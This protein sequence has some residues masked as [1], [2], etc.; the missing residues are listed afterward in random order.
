MTSCSRNAN[1]YC[2]KVAHHSHLLERGFQG[3]PPSRLGTPEC[4]EIAVVVRSPTP[5]FA[6]HQHHRETR[7]SRRAHHGPGRAH[8]RGRDST[9]VRRRA[10]TRPPP[11]D[12][13]GK[14]EDGS[15]DGPVA[16]RKAGRWPGVSRCYQ[17]IVPTS[18]YSRRRRASQGPV[19]HDSRP[20]Y[21]RLSEPSSSGSSGAARRQRP[22]VR[23][24][25]RIERPASKP[26]QGIAT[27]ATPHLGVLK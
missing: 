20:P 23:R 19:P 17:V 6:G 24:C 14:Q 27:E 26:C 2:S 11:P 8:E 12:C 3:W 10:V 4:R 5:R 22:R 9:A 25:A 16:P 21:A 1:A 18:P 13:G 15:S 7:M